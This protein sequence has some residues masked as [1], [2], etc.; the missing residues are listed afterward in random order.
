MPQQG[1]PYNTPSVDVQSPHCDL[2]ATP[3][4]TRRSKPVLCP[5]AFNSADRATKY[6]HVT[7]IHVVGNSRHEDADP[8]KGAGNVQTISS[9][10]AYHIVPIYINQLMN[11][12]TSY[13][14]VHLASSA[15]TSKRRNR[16]PRARYN[17]Q[18]AKLCDEIIVFHKQT[19]KSTSAYFMPRQL[20][21]PFEKLIN[22]LS[23]TLD[24]GW[25]HRSGRNSCGRTKISSERVTKSGLWLTTV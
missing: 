1:P 11:S 23:K 15:R 24:S 20:R 22:Q 8:R 21:G 13:G 16:C 4:T 17:S 9:R 12:N 7:I 19:K 14:T 25:S 10:Q 18:Y 6:N 2:L 5:S 3:L